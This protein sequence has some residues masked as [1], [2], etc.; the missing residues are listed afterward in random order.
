MILNSQNV[1]EASNSK[2]FSEDIDGY[3]AKF[4]DCLNDYQEDTIVCVPKD[5]TKNDSEYRL[6]N[7]EIPWITDAARVYRHC[8]YNIACRRLRAETWT[9][10]LGVDGNLIEIGNL[11]V[12]QDDTIAVGIGEGAEIKSVSV[13]GSYIK[14]ITVDYPFAVSDITK[15]YGVKIQHSDRIHGVKVV[16]YEVAKFSKIGEYSVLTFNSN[17]IS[18]NEGIVPTIGD[19]VAFGIFNRITTDALCFGK[20]DNGDGTFTLTLVPYQ[21]GIYDAESGTIPKF[22]SNVTSPKEN[23]SKLSE[24]LPSPT[25]KDVKEIAN[26]VVSS[27]IDIN[28][29]TLDI[30][31]EAQGVPSSNDGKLGSSWLYISA[32][33]YYMDKQ[34]TDNIT[35]KAYLSSGDEVGQW[36]GNKVKISTG[37]LKGDVLY[38]TIKVI[39]KI[40]DLNIVEREVQAQ[41]S[42]LYGADSTKIYK[43]LFP[44]GE[45]VKVDKTGEII[46]PE[47]LRAVKRVASGNAENDTTFGKI[48]LETLPA[49]EEKDYSGYSQVETTESFSEKKTYYHATV[50]FLVKAGDNAVIG[51]GDKS[52]AL[53]FMEKLK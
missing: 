7:I 32:Y 15:T 31:P 4:I 14:S 29:Y 33:L 28:K 45:K 12:V 23:G 11:V 27:T 51:D 10:K 30:S 26:N 39:Y 3:S 18:L 16:T 21:K 44:D 38:I 50:P 46:E 53:F 42:R 43:M 49:G 48:T 20:K 25:Y 24:E 8:M 13:S 41:I 19:I 22:I 37:F 17:G 36:D 52:G 47:Q 40:D 5:T 2:S 34:I 1:L 6:E 35:Y 9:R